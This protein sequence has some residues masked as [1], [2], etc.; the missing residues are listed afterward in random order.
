M[1]TLP[2]EHLRRAEKTAETML[3]STLLRYGMILAT[4]TFLGIMAAVLVLWP[5]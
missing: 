1:E 4:I 3:V 2:M 5:L